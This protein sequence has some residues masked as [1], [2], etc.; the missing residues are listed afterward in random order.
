MKKI[1]LS[2]IIAF[3]VVGVSI[4]NAGFNDEYV[5]TDLSYLHLDDKVK[6]STSRYDIN[7]YSEGG[8]TTSSKKSSDGFEFGF[9]S[10]YVDKIS[11]VRIM[12][13][14]IERLKLEG[15][16]TSKLKIVDIY[17]SKNFY[18]FSP[19]VCV[20]VGGGW[21]YVDVY[22]Q[23]A[24]MPF[25]GIRLSTKLTSTLYSMV[26]VDYEVGLGGGDIANAY[27]TKFGLLYAID[28]NT[29]LTADIGTKHFNANNDVD[30]KFFTIGFKKAF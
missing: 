4:A 11:Q 18:T 3:L 28:S 26:R 9:E 20:D 25:W 21:K 17:G 19:Y 10:A 6:S 23:D 30:S 2:A 5:V 8:E 7:G 14:M 27:E 1:K 16:L 22:S 24:I 29:G 13:G 15:A 12:G